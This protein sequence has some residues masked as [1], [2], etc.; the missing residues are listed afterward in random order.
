[1]A[2][3]IFKILEA[4]AK[5]KGIN[6]LNVLSKITDL[7]RSTVHRILQSMV[8]CGMVV[9]AAEKGYGLSG[10]LLSLCIENNQNADFLEVMI[11]FAKKVSEQTH[12]TTS[13]SI[14]SGLERLRIYRSEGDKPA[15]SKVQV[16]ELGPL[17]LGS[18]GRVL[19]A[20]LPPIIFQEALEYAER[21]GTVAPGDRE[22]LLSSI[23]QCKAAGYTVSIEERYAGC[24][25]VAVP[26]IKS[27]TKEVLGALSINSV[28]SSYSEAAQKEYAELLM[29]AAAEASQK[30][31]C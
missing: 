10:K 7:P 24:W 31:I 14:V 4:I 3:K 21:N 8:E 28:L 23:E 12:E 11:P 13:I 16:G 15:I 6:S 17:F 2:D 5:T 9:F 20:Y 26:I 29:D 27:M 1:M 19:A 30:L 18:T 22:S 25:S